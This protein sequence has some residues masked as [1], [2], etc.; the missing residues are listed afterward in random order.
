MMQQMQQMV[1]QLAEELMNKSAEQSAQI[2]QEAVAPLAEAVQ[3]N[4]EQIKMTQE[5]IPPIAQ[6]VEEISARLAQLTQLAM[7]EN[8]RNPNPPEQP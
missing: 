4:G 2:T 1:A 6:S 3:A 7:S 8:G 5:A